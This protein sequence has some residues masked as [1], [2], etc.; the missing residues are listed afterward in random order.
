[1]RIRLPW[2]A[3]SLAALFLLAAVPGASEA[4]PP[5]VD[6]WSLWS[7]GT[8]KLRGA[9]IYQRRV[10]PEIDGTQ[11]LGPGPFGPPYT[12]ADFDRLAALGANYVNISH[13]GLYTETP[14]PT[15]ELDP[16]AV[17]NLDG[18]LD[19][20]RAAGMYAVIS[21]RTGPGRSEFTFFASAVGTFFD[22]SYLNDTVWAPTAG[23]AAA[24]AAWAA[25][26]GETARLYRTI[27]S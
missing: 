13:P 5:V 20:I 3:G 9:N 7:A 24:R 1:M 15:Y 6:K 27:R 21:F 14:A 10:Y 18:L 4:D 16:A 11:F 8:T 19:K 22:A 26:W 12:Q 17:A 25:M 23:G 2:L